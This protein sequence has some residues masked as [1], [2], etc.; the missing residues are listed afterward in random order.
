MPRFVFDKAEDALPVSPTFDGDTNLDNNA[1]ATQDAPKGNYKDGVIGG[2]QKLSSGFA[3][4]KKGD[5]TV[6]SYSFYYAHNKAGDY[7]RND[8][9]TAQ[10]YL[11]PGPDGK[12]QPE[13]LMTSWHHGEVLTPWKD[14]PKDED[15]R[16]IVGVN[17][18]SHALEVR[19]KVPAEGLSIKGN[20]QALLNGKPIDQAMTFETF[21]K[22]VN[23]AQYLDP[24]K[25]EAKPRLRA[26]TWGA[27]P[28]DPFLP[29][30]FQAQPG[31]WGQIFQRGEAEAGKFAKGLVAK[32][33]HALD[34]A[35]DK[36]KDGVS[37]VV[38]KA[39]DV[40]DGAKDMLV[41]SA[42]GAKGLVKSALNLF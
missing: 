22:N 14:L 9:S 12:L 2:D 38:D 20:G 41:D 26:M 37:S 36:V 11:K 29:E 24:S 23:G 15:G 13:Y 42:K 35:V 8:Y 32:A 25:D 39:G 10:V 17:L 28:F 19:D 27:A 16:P 33:D 1:A 31:A 21:Q 6:L 7:H 40:A 30:V 3:V 18:G 5:Y 34:G 4:T